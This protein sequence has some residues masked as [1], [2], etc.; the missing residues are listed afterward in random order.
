MAV[1]SNDLIYP[2]GKLQSTMFR[3]ENLATLA[4]A[5]LD[6][7]ATKVVD[8]AEEDKDAAATHWVYYRAYSTIAE[9][10]GVNPS[11]T[12][13]G[14]NSGGGVESTE[15]WGQNRADYWEKKAAAE[16]AEFERLLPPDSPATP[17]YHFALAKGRRGR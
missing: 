9:R 8:V 12:S 14:G 15:D 17:S 4:D 6:Q 11:R 10:I 2:K 13:F 7:A 3:G 16:L 5:W 1:T